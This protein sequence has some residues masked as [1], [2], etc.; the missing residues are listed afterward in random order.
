MTSQKTH[1][2]QI[3]KKFENGVYFKCEMC[4]AC[5]RGFKDG[6][7]YLYPDDVKK[8]A[9]HLNV[10]GNSELREFA[11]KYF[12]IVDDSFYWK[13]PD[14]T[15]AKT[16]RYKTL[17]FKFIGDDEHCQFLKDN[18]CTIHEARPFQCRAFPIGWNM[19]INNVKNFIDYSKKCPALHNSLENK[20][21]FYSKEE[22]LEWASEEYEIEKAFFF[23]MKK[24]DF[25]IFKAYKFLSKDIPLIRN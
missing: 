15:R 19:L 7:V 8:L 6:E 12:K 5:C 3:A 9:K 1:K 13:E 20:G 4:G 16:Y 11:K 25:D 24:N 14:A 21:K 17:G 22:I 18:K 23:R 2:I 10:K